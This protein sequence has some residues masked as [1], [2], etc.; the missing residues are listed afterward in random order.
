[1][2]LP[3]IHN[4][5]HCASHPLGGKAGII[6]N[7][8]IWSEN[9]GDIPFPRGRTPASI[10]VSSKGDI[11]VQDDRDLGNGR[12]GD[13]R[14]HLFKPAAREWEDR[15]ACYGGNAILFKRNGELVV[16]NGLLPGDPETA[17]KAPFG[18][19][20]EDETNGRIVTAAET[21]MPSDGINIFQ[22][23]PLFGGAARVGEGADENGNGVHIWIADEGFLRV[24]EPGNCQF[25]VANEDGI[26]ADI[27]TFRI[28]GANV[29][30]TSIIHEAL[31]LAELQK[32]PRLTI[33]LPRPV[34]SPKFA[35]PRFLG[36]HNV[37]WKGNRI[38][39]MDGSLYAHLLYV[40]GHVFANLSDQDFDRWFRSVVGPYIVYWDGLELP[41]VSLLRV[42]VKGQ[43]IAVPVY[44]EVNEPDVSL[45]TRANAVADRIAL[46]GFHC[47]PVPGFH[48]RTTNVE[49]ITPT[50]IRGCI[51]NVYVP[52]MRR[53]DNLGALPFGIGRLDGTVNHPEYLDWIHAIGEAFPSGSPLPILVEVTPTPVPNP[54][55]PKDPPTLPIPPP[56]TKGRR[57]LTADERK[58][59][60]TVT[61]I[62]G[63]AR[64]KWNNTTRD[65]V[66]KLTH[67]E[68]RAH[69]VVGM[70]EA[71]KITPTVAQVMELLQAYFDGVKDPDLERA[72]A[73]DTI[74]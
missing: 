55:P 41:P 68:Q 27:G 73:L 60:L 10:I 71:K 24:L 57:P 8:H 32:S 61:G 44:A 14:A 65:A 53:W 4:G 21:L 40:D 6:K 33:T 47:V 49:N 7:S 54:P 37:M 34:I 18:L 11:A 39:R 16:F 50:R 25:V 12:T 28:N 3:E 62:M 67:A 22:W 72:V 42:I 74:K 48:G 30:S 2:R 1:M 5:T 56:P 59:L 43:G 58:E 69:E 46:A 35:K 45:F 70:F 23:T 29:P 17:P 64:F 15:G 26:L 13:D 66:T 38:E 19:R 63:A 52:L 51:D 20:Y 31:T 9:Y 36:G